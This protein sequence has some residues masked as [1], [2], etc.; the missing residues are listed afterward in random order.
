MVQVAAAPT[1]IAQSPQPPGGAQPYGGQMPVTSPVPPQTG[2]QTAPPPPPQPSAQQ[3][4]V[5]QQQPQQQQQ[6]NAGFGYAPTGAGGGGGRQV[7]IWEGH[8]EWAE[9][10]RNNPNIKSTHVALA[11][12]YSFMTAVVDPAT[13]QYASEVA[14]A[15]AQTWP[16]KISLQM[17]S[18]QI[19]DILSPWCAPPA[20]NLIL[21]TDNQDVKNSLT[22]VGV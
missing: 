10:D 18:K 11:A 9:K 3:P 19:L 1:G 16:A 7:Q 22:T 4:Q 20:R 2:V 13:G 8:I 6:A 15:S 17:M 12:M 5:Y 14:L 21:H